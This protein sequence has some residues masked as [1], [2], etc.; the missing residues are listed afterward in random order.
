MILFMI[1]EFQ[2]MPQSTIERDLRKEQGNILSFKIRAIAT[3]T[4]SG[5]S[6]GNDN[7]KINKAIINSEAVRVWNKLMNNGC[8]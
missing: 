8:Y 1:Q 4:N 7:I 6:S 3:V 2:N 5:A